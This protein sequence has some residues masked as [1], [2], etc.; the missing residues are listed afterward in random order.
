MP[1]MLVQKGS[2]CVAEHF[3]PQNRRKNAFGAPNAFLQR[4]YF[5][6]QNGCKNAFLQGI[7]FCSTKCNGLLCF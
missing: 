6:L 3:V 4:V 2:W 1:A 5:V 7:T